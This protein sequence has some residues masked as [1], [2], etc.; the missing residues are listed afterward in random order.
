MDM[1][2]VSS[3]MVPLTTDAVA[4]AGPAGESAAKASKRSAHWKRA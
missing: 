1:V 4:P 3:G 2:M